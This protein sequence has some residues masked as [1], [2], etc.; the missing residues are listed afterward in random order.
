MYHRLVRKQIF[1]TLGLVANRVN[2]TDNNLKK[3]KIQIYNELKYTVF[4]PDQMTTI[5][6]IQISAQN[7]FFINIKYV[8]FFLCFSL[9]IS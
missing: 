4:L 3:Y 5:F 7:G 2:I 8:F 9:Y 6:R 1:N